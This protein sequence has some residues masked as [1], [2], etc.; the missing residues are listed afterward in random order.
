MIYGERIMVFSGEFHPYRLP[1]PGLW[2]DVFQKVKALGF[3]TVS[4]YVHWALL[5]GQPGHFTADGVFAFEPFF[6]AAQKAGIYLIARPGPVSQLFAIRIVTEILA[7]YQ[8][9]IQRRGFSRLASTNQGTAPYKSA[10]LSCCY[11]QLCSQYWC[12]HCQGANHQW[13]PSYPPSARKRIHWIH[14]KCDWWISGPSV[15]RLCQEAIQRRW[16]SRPIH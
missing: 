7:V 8:C 13:W 11:R 3:N 9:G 12:N 10:R 14:W 4:F 5:E 1:V 16:S 6:D 2:L 15:L